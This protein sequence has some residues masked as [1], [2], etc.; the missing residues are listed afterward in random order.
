[1]YKVTEKIVNK[2]NFEVLKDLTSF[3][4]FDNLSGLKDFESKNLKK[5]KKENKLINHFKN[6][7]NKNDFILEISVSTDFMKVYIY[8]Q[9][10][11]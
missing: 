8:D 11:H 2:T 1:M 5:A 7:M 4:M 3:R 9:N 6:R 10:L